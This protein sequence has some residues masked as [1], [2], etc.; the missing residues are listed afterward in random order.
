[1]KIGKPIKYIAIHPEEVLDRVKKAIKDDAAKQAEM[2]DE[3][4]K[5]D[6]LDQLKLLHTKGVDLIDPTDLTGALKGRQNAYDQL[7]MMIK[8]AAQSVI[9]V[10]T[11][12]GLPRKADACG[13]VLKKAAERG[14]SI[15]IAAPITA[16]N[17]G[18]VDDL[19]KFSE[20]RDLKDMHARFCIVDGKEVM[21]M[22]LDDTE[23]HPS[24]DVGV[25]LNA[26]Y[27]CEALTQLF[28]LAWKE[29]R[30]VGKLEKP[31]K[32]K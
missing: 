28:S 20:V 10:T 26:P 7:D 21:F 23:V 31:L 24:Y 18:V 8:G 17:K 16:K 32:V 4:R 5:T 12:N 29:L 9:L 25:W 1:M 2:L 11:E 3:L 6:I 30:V 22:L 14:V 27:F 19:E 15:R 13:R